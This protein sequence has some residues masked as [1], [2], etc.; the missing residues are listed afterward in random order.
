MGSS[1][2]VGMAVT[3]SFTPSLAGLEAATTDC[4]LASCGHAGVAGGAPHPAPVACS[5]IRGGGP[6]GFSFYEGRPDSQDQK[7]IGWGG[8][9]AAPGFMGRT[10]LNL[11]SSTR[12][13]IW[14]VSP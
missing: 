10:A 6:A 13:T 12:T 14:R 9:P 2:E 5:F 3:G 1:G 8:S 4:L 7:A 11:A